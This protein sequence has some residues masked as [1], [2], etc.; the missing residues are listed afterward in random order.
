MLLAF[1]IALYFILGLGFWGLT[2]LVL[3][4]WFGSFFYVAPPIRYGYHG[5]ES[6]R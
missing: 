5:R 3:L 2:P 4:A 1:G 6:F